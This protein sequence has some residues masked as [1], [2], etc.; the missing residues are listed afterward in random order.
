MAVTAGRFARAVIGDA[1]DAAQTVFKQAVGGAL[2]FA[3]NIGIRRTAI[4]RIIFEAAVLGGIMRRRNH[5]A[6][7]QA[8]LAAFVIGDNGAGNNRRRGLAIFLLDHHLYAPRR[9]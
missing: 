4:G 5:H 2:D 7:G 1:F 6:V 3:R 8:I 9:Q